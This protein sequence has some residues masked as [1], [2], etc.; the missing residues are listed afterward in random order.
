MCLFDY[1]GYGL[2]SN[3]VASE[4]SCQQDVIA[5]YTHLIKH[6]KLLAEEIVIYVKNLIN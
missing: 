2:H 1:A 4:Y 6:K 3:R 5:V